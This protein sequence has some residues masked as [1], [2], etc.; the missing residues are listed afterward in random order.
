ME[1]IYYAILNSEEGKQWFIDKAEMM[2]KIK[3]FNVEEINAVI[4]YFEILF[5]TTFYV[6][7][8]YLI[9]EAH[10]KEC[11]SIEN[12]AT[13]LVSIIY[14]VYE[15][16]KA[17]ICVKLLNMTKEE[18]IGCL[19]YSRIDEDAIKSNLNNIKNTLMKNIK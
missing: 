12:C 4:K 9:D 1:E 17:L 5:N 7:G 11:L 14:L 10:N 3:D 16:Y 2:Y 6:D 15:K 19:D 13:M 18:W 8:D